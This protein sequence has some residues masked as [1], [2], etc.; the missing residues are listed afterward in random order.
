MKIAELKKEI[1]KQLYFIAIIPPSPILEEAQELKNYFS[2]RYKSKASL[3]SPPHMTLHMPF[4]WKEEN[5][6]FL[7]E[8]LSSFAQT[9]NKFDVMLLNFGCF[10]PRVIFID[11]V[12]TEGLDKLQRNL[13]RFCKKELNLFNAT[14]KE[15]GFH[16]HVTLA[17]RDLKKSMFSKAWDEFREKKFNGSFKV[18]SIILLK[19]D[20]KM[21]Q[22][23]YEANLRR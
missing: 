3:N 21:W 4:Q 17:F 13:H 19:H 12:K 6:N 16:P 2:D 10:E 7:I 8:R 1:T 18:S 9:Q 15:D 5:E 14:Y 22:I 11:V 20:G 23:F